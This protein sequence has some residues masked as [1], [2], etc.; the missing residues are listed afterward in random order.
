MPV[1]VICHGGAWS[2]PDAA[3]AESQKGVREAARAGLEALKNGQV[4][5]KQV[6]LKSPKNSPSHPY[7]PLP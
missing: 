1:Q 5:Y 3:A 6:S 4:W 7:Y 2:I